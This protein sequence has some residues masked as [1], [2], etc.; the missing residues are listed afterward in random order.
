LSPYADFLDAARRDPPHTAIVLG[1]G[2]GGLADILADA[3]IISFADVPQLAGATVAGHRGDLLLGKWS[4][5][6]VLVFAGRL[7]YYEGHSW[8]RVVAPVRIAKEIGV[9]VFLATNAVGGIRADLTGGT[10]VALRDHLEWTRP[11]FWRQ[12]D[13]GGLGLARPSPYS[14]ALIERL[15]TAARREGFELPTGVYAQV[16]GPS[17]E[18]PSE[19]EALRRC[20]AD[21]VG[22]STAREIQIGVEL[23]L[24]CAAVSCVCNQAAGLSA[25]PI[26]HTEVLDVAAQMRERLTRLVQRF[27]EMN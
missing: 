10:L 21:V 17:Y 20:G 1:T 18:T 7:H 16:T 12:P 23:G 14:P 3:T 26:Q 27:L 6:R 25:V 4:G 24:E 5:Q 13:P 11:F 8:E 9:R 22:M 15:Q 19:I 2:L